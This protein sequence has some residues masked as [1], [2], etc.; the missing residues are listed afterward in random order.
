METYC[1]H[2]DFDVLTVSSLAKGTNSTVL[3]YLVFFECCTLHAI[4]SVTYTTAWQL[5]S[6]LPP[7]CVL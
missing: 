5:Q 1:Q 3:Y 4:S 2:E 7:D 6:T